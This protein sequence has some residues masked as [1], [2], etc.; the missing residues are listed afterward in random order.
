MPS[1]RGTAIVLGALIV[2][3]T[4]CSG[5]DS[6]PRLELST[7]LPAIAANVLAQRGTIVES[8]PAQL[9]DDVM[10]KIGQASTV[11][12]RSVSGYDGKASEVAGTVFVPKG[13]PPDG[14]WPVIAYAHVTTGTTVDCGPSLSA[15]LRGT[16]SSIAPIVES[17]FAV[18][19]TDYQGLGHPGG[20]PYLEPKTAAFDVIDSVRA[21]RNVYPNVSTRWLAFGSS[22]G[23]QAAW[24]ANEYAADYGTGLDFLGSISIAPPAD[25]TGYAVAAESETLTPGQILFMPLIIAGLQVVHPD[26]QP[27]DYLRGV[28]LNDQ[29][30]LTSCTTPEAANKKALFGELNSAQVRPSSKEAADRLVGWL[31]DSA[32]PQRRASG[33]MFVVNGSLDDVVLP[34]WVSSAVSR[35]C[36][37]GDTIIH[38]EIADRGHTDVDGGEEMY[39]WIRDR[40][41][42]AEAPSNCP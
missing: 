8:K 20:H 10:A 18:A 13:S 25:F 24:A 30:A 29:L 15:D 11:V 32:L 36:E 37:A 33:P 39:A 31:K 19:M 16:A 3:V 26:L 38:R 14:G 4:A 7:P 35:A 42:G 41:T 40:F 5:T 23:G 27:S 28:A 22:Q 21:L 1:S 34:A 17:G 2:L 6:K 9:P 12:Y